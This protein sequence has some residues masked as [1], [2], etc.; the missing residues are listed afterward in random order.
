METFIFTI[1]EPKKRSGYYVTKGVITAVDVVSARRLVSKQ[2]S[3]KENAEI[4]IQP[5]QP[6]MFY[7]ISKG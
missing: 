3:L 1:R 5:T 7:P 6:E 2:M 4:S